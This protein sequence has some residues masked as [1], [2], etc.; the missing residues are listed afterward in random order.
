MT[1]QGIL[2]FVA[3]AVRQGLKHQTIKCYLS[4]VRH[5]QVCSGGG[6]P[7]IGSM[8]QLELSLRGSKKEQLGQQKPT[9]LPIT[10]AILMK[11]RQVWD[12]QAKERHAVGSM[13]PWF[14][15]FLRSGEF[16]APESD[17]FDPGQHLSFTDVAVDSLDSPRCLSIKI[18][19]S[20]TDPFRQGVTICLGKTEAL[21]CPVGAILSYLVMRG[22]GGGPLFRFRD[23]RALT[24]PRLVVEIR[25]ALAQAGIN[26]DDYAGHS[27]HIGAATTAAACG[28]PVDIIKTLGR[29]KS[30]AYQLYVRL[31]REQLSGISKTLASSKV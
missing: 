19:Q 4:A 13:L 30:N 11:L 16:T 3:F 7:G 15:G 29:W 25:K 9:R 6:D 22:P 2:L 27:F 26:P 10:P 1:E 24:R 12:K 20:K 18:K 8:P 28:V 17:E 14:F 31:P 21:F 5:L 23:G